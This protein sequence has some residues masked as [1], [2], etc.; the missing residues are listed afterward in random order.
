MEKDFVPL[1]TSREEMESS[2]KEY[3]MAPK[4]TPRLSP[5]QT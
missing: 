5:I 1:G 3:I 2:V 4:G